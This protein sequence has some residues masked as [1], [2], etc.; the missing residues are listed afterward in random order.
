MDQ[1]AALQWVKRNFARVGGDP[2]NVTVAGES[3]GAQDVGL[4][5]A[6]PD[7]WRL[8]HKAI[9]AGGDEAGH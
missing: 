3:A 4:P 6:A 7:A 2:G 1:I 5:L 8:F 9:S